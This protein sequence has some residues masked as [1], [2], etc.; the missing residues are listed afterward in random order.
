MLLKLMFVFCQTVPT[1]L[2]NVFVQSRYI[3][4]CLSA[5]F[6]N[7]QIIIL[8]PFLYIHFSTNIYIYI[9]NYI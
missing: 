4:Y 7:V 1:V 2:F 3:L 6:I 5:H 8:F 9:Y